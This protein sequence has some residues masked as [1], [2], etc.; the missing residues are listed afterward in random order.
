MQ[1]GLFVTALAVAVGWAGFW[2]APPALNAWAW[3]SAQDDPAA[4]TQLGLR[5]DFNAARLQSELESALAA[6]DV[7][8]AASFV[9]L[10]A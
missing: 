10:A 5:A 1:R 8:M 7:D 4:L 6:D 3:I 9:A 2:L